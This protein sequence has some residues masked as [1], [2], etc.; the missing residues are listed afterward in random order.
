MKNV[1]KLFPSLKKKSKYLILFSICVSIIE[2]FSI[3]LLIPL[4]S[5]LLESD[6]VGFSFLDQFNFSFKD[7]NDGFVYLSTGILIFFLIKNILSYL[8]KKYIYKYCFLEQKKLRLRLFN[9]YL[10][11]PYEKII[12][13]D[14]SKKFSILTELTRISTES[15]LIYFVEFF[16]NILI[17]FAIFGFLLSYNFQFTV[18]ISILFLISSFFLKK[19]IF[20]KIYSL[21]MKNTLAYKGIVKFSETGINAIKELKV[22]LKEGLLS[23]EMKKTSDDFSKSQ[24]KF[25][26]IQNLPKYIIEIIIISGILS[27]GF[28][29]LTQEHQINKVI[30]TMGV[31]VFISLRMA[32]LVNQILSCYSN[33]SRSKYAVDTLIDEIN[34]FESLGNN[35]Y[36]REDSRIDFSNELEIKNFNFKYGEKIIFKEA[37][38]KI[39]FGETVALH[40]DSGSGKTTL[41]YLLLGFLKLNGEV[42]VDKKNFKVDYLNIINSVSYIPQEPYMLNDSI[43]NNILFGSRYNSFLLDRALKES[44]LKS[45]VSDFKDGLKTIVGHEGNNISGGQ[46]QRISIARAIY[47]NKKFI[48]LDEPNTFLD[49]KSKQVLLDTLKKI[50]GK[51]TILIVS[52]DDIFDNFCDRIYYLKNKKLVEN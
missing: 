32:P 3:A 37:N 36:L 7:K 24:V 27:L 25:L 1:F 33:I 5:V 26:L 50:K 43:I 17:A 29:I 38:F 47:N 45:L 31:Y 4:L 39:K 10:F 35:I 2:L 41:I 30:I 22:Y 51:C 21:G 8:L 6:Y 42:S 49:S 46:K 18:F 23:D 13:S 11:S 9:F 15:F 20:N 28:Y 48:I 52:H 19:M 14:Y 34:F 44:N 40:G 16:S 12:L